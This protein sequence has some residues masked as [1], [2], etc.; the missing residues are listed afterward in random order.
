[1]PRLA[2]NRAVVVVGDVSDV[3]IEIAWQGPSVRNQREATYDADVLSDLLND[4]R[5]AFQRRLVDTG[6]FQ[7]IGIGYRTLANTGPIT[8]HAVTTVKKLAGALTGLVMEL[9]MMS[10]TSYF[11][12]TDLEIA[13]KRR[14]V[15]TVLSLE[16]GLG[17]A[18]TFGDFW[19]VAGLDYQLGYVENLSSRSLGDVSHFVH[20]YLSDKPFVI[21]ALTSQKDAQEVSKTLSLYLDF[22]AQP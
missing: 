16:Q 12:P 18:A 19:S 6:L 7:S 8:L 20:D 22:V 10:D 2:A 5:S 11:S 14:A 4:D 21:G 13:K 1:M 17:L 15:A 9:R 3:T